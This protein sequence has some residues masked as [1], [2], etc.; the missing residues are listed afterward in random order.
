VS[1][2][3]RIRVLIAEDDQQVREALSEL[4]TSERAL[5]LAGVVS[6]AQQ[7]VDIAERLQPDVALLDVRMPGGGPRAARGIRRR[8]PKTRILAFSGHDDRATVLEMLEAGAAGYLV[9]GC[10][11]DAIVDSIRRAALG[12]GSLSVEVVGKVVDELVGELNV[13]RRLEAR[14]L[15]HQR[16]I[17]RA[18]DTRNVL[19]MVFQP[20]CTLSGTAIGAEA[21]ARF[22]A[23]PNRG[24]DGWFA[25]ADM[26]GLRAELELAAVQ[27]ALGSLAQLPI[28]MFVSINVSPETICAASFQ[29]LVAESGERVVVEITEHAPIQDYD[30]MN[31]ALTG[32]RS[33]NVRL[34]ID[35]AGAGYASLR[36]ILRLEPDYIKLDRTL[37]HMIDSE[38][39]QQAL[40]VGLISFAQSIEATIIAEGIER[41]AEVAML[42]KLGVS[43]GQGFFFGKPAP[44]P[45]VT[46]NSRLRGR[47]A[48]SS[49]AGAVRQA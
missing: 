33:N 7:A 21:L 2:E 48:R 11:V 49:P 3:R 5:E 9:K 32:L 42:E 36:H 41:P 45:L 19:S 24:P 20:I 4:I 18:L 22:R 30:R 8:S 6:D 35:D 40:A 25:E 29:D 16:R 27:A 47:A 14:H 12:Q 46:R 1:R 17:R 15:L 23:P 28:E 44:L 38:R 31:E 37:I 43:Y 34:A 39:S 10:S 26:V 13:R